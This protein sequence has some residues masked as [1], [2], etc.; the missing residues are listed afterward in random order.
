MNFSKRNFI[1]IL[2]LS[3]LFVLTNFKY[4]FAATKEII[5]QN[6]D[7]IIAYGC[8]I[9]KG[10]LLNVFEGRFLNLHLGLSPYYRG[11]GTNFW[12]LVNGEPEYVGATFMY[13]DDGIDTGAIVHQIRARMFLGDTPHQIGNRLIADCA[14]QYCG[15]IRNV[16]RL[17]PVAPSACDGKLYK[18]SD[19]S[20][21]SVLGLYNAFDNG[22]I[23]SYLQNREAR[24]VVVPICCN[25]ILRTD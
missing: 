23:E 13:I 21:Q 3:T 14:V 25:P 12:P 5:N 16:D 20:V 17:R 2:S 19:F 22:M 7:L 9:I 18:R 24:D 1:R 6:P 4:L 11:A 15:I 8:S 10:P